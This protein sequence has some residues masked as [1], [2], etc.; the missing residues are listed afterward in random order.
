M[1]GARCDLRNRPSFE[2]PLRLLDFHGKEMEWCIGWAFAVIGTRPDQV[3][4]AGVKIG[5]PVHLI[6]IVGQLHFRLPVDRNRE[7]LQHVFF[8]AFGTEDDPLVIWREKWSAVIPRLVGQ[9][10]HIRAI[11]IHNIKIRITVS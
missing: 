4:A 9:L 8:L 11:G 10:T 3:L 7:L 2:S 6:Q 1:S 5:T